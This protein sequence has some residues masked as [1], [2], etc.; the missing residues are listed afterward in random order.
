MLDSKR[1][2]GRKKSIDK[3]WVSQKIKKKICNLSLLYS[4]NDI[5]DILCLSSFF[6]SFSI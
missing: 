4:G 6:P 3:V 2:G 1:Q 5:N